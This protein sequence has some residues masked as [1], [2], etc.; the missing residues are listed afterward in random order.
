MGNESLSSLSLISDVIVGGQG[1]ASAPSDHF[2]RDKGIICPPPSDN[3][4]VQ[5]APFI[6]E[7]LWILFNN[8]GA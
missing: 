3:P 1:W 7:L 6:N 8:I 2:L 4:T 5:I